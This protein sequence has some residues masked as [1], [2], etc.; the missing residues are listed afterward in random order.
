[1]MLYFYSQ[2]IYFIPSASYTVLTLVKIIVST[3]LRYNK[4]L[5][6]FLNLLI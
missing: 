2:I 1:M 4:L 5:R 6:T 3:F